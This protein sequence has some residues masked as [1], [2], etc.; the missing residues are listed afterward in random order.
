MY[1][2]PVSIW[3]MMFIGKPSHTLKKTPST[4]CN[5]KSHRNNGV[6]RCMDMD[7]LVLLV[8]VRH[9]FSTSYRE[10]S[11]FKR[12]HLDLFLL[13]AR[14]IAFLGNYVNVLHS[15]AYSPTTIVEKRVR[16]Q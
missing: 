10:E 15:Q 5:T 11:P 2:W 8:Q 9:H 12:C 6:C 14:G 13:E 16:E 3:L 7:C 4:S 1:D